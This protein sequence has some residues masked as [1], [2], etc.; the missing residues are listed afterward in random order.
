M[1]FVLA[2]T[3]GEYT[4]SK[5]YFATAGK[6]PKIMPTLIIV[7]SVATRGFL[8][9]QLLMLSALTFELDMSNS[10]TAR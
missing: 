2:N 6:D 1:V 8:P 4:Y 10:R 5:S 7:C 3:F 9:D